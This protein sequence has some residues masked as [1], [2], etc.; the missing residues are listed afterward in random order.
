MPALARDAMATESEL[1]AL[2][3]AAERALPPRPAGHRF[4]ADVEISEIDERSR[5]GPVWVAK[6]TE[7][8]KSNV[9]VTSRRMCYPGRV[10]AIAI[11]LI[12]DRPV[13]LLAK[14]VTC[15]YSDDGMYRVDLDL[16]KIPEGH[17]IY[18]WA[19]ARGNAHRKR[20]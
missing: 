10:L 4:A 16:L 2:T 8:S 17:S 6:T 7:L 12:D 15:H 19:V 3:A 9:V 11:H 20:S 1:A 14:V 18:D 13:P 5:P